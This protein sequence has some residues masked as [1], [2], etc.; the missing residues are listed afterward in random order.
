MSFIGRQTSSPLTKVLRE[1]KSHPLKR[2]E[3]KTTDVGT[4]STYK[5]KERT[6]TVLTM[7]DRTTFPLSVRVYVCDTFVSS[8]NKSPS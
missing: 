8:T 7:T 6:S 2:S 3:K 1:E 4:G 5:T